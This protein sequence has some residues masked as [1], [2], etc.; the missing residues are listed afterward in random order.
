MRRREPEA[1]VCPKCG[2][3]FLVGGT[4][5]PPVRQ[6]FCSRVCAGREIAATRPPRTSKYANTLRNEAWLRSKYIDEGLGPRQIAA[7]IGCPKNTVDWALH[8]LGI[9]TR[10]VSEGRRIRYRGQVLRETT[11]AEVVAAYGGRCACCGETEIEFLSLD[12]TDGGGYQHRRARGNKIYGDLKA[13]GWPQDGY[14][15][16]CMNCQFGTMRGRICPHQRERV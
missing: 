12:H 13:A 10:S 14:R 9:P 15:I 4:G 1:R 11:K 6:K 3:S 5:H 7:L 8:F 2:N 16:L